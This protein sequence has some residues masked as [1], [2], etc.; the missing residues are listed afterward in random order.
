VLSAEPLCRSCRKRGRV[1]VAVD[2]DHILSLS[3]G[4]TY[5][6]DNLQ[7]LCLECHADKSVSELGHSRKQ[8]VNA[9]GIPIDRDGNEIGW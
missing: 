2:V 1:T 8:A 5:A 3:A 6:R 4:G 9:R 7:P